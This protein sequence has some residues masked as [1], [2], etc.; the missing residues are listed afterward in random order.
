MTESA[1]ELL[2]ITLVGIVL[3]WGMMQDWRVKLQGI[4]LAVKPRRQRWQ[5]EG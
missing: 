4:G 5:S 2:P 1:W 3:A